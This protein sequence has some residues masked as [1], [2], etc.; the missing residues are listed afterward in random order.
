MKLKKTKLI[1]KLAA[2]AEHPEGIEG[3]KQKLEI[4][5]ATVD[6]FFDSIKQAVK[7]GDRVELRGFGSFTGRQ[8]KGYIG[9]NPKTGESVKVRPKTLP[10]FR[11]STTLKKKINKLSDK[12]L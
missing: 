10:F 12:K 3:D 2:T 5:K 11:I 9:R 6:L 4:A 7:H 1:E 8:Y